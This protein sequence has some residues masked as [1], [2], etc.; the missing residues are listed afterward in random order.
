[1]KKALILSTILLTATRLAG[2]VDYFDTSLYSPA[3]D[4]EK[5]V[6]VYLPPGYGE[7]PELHY[8]VVYYLHGWGGNHTSGSRLFPVIDSL[9]RKGIINPMVLVLADNSCEPFD[10]SHY[11]NSILW[12]NYEDFMTT[13]LIAWVDSSFRTIPERNG[14]ALMGQSM[15]AYG[16]FR[17]GILHKDKFG[18]LAAHAGC[19]DFLDSVF[20]KT[21]HANVLKENQPGPPYFYDYENSGFWTQMAFLGWGAFAPDFNSPQKNINPPIVWFPYDENGLPVD[22]LMPIARKS[23][24]NYLIQQLSPADSVGVFFGCGSQ[25][26][27]MFYPMNINLKSILDNRGLPY[28]FYDH[29]GDHGM[30]KGFLEHGLVFL[31]SLMLKPRE[32]VKMD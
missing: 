21:I 20:L 28:V 31:D 32:I 11:V 14:R 18:A 5:M 12:G 24:I 13:D 9:I 17:Y 10:G 1:M 27:F 26:R 8:P 2:Q 23:S 29:D 16:S 19:V 7:N 15:G 30:P 6:R 22:T 4:K 3:L 25:D